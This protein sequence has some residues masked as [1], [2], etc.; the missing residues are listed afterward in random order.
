VQGE[1]LMPVIAGRETADRPAPMEVGGDQ[2]PCWQWRGLSDGRYAM[3]RR[4]KD[5]P[6]RQPIPPLFPD[7]DGARP[8]WYLFD[9]VAD[10]LERRNLAAEDMPRAQAMFT[11]LQEHGWY[12]APEALL[13]MQAG[14]LE[15]D[16]EQ[17]HE[18]QQLG[19]GGAGEGAEPHTP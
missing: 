1:S 5:L 8:R 18:L 10:P 9:L 7:D 2:K 3:L 19:Y 17:A 14:A 16:P 13:G 15:L 12:V 4:E 11:T 6:T